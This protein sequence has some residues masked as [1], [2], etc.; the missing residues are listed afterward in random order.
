[1]DFRD[2]PGL[3][4]F[5]NILQLYEGLYE[6]TSLVEKLTRCLQ[7][8]LEEA[9]IQD[10]AVSEHHRNLISI[11]KCLIE[12]QANRNFIRIANLLQGEVAALMPVWREMLGIL[13]RKV[14]SEHEPCPQAIESSPAG[15]PNLEPCP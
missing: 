6:L 2:T 8:N 3:E 7:I 4:A 11:L 9:R 5:Q 12:S 14:N 13:Q 10:I 1:M 15:C